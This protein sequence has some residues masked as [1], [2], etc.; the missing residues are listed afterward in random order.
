MNDERRD[1]KLGVLGSA[2]WLWPRLSLLLGECCSASDELP[3]DD[4]TDRVDGLAGGGMEHIVMV[5]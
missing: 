5:R 1:T 4:A 3:C 2:N